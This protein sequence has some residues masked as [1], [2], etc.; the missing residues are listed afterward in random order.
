MSRAPSLLDDARRAYS[1]KAWD[2]AFRALSQID[3]A[4]GLGAEDLERLVWSASMLDLDAEIL[5]TMERL[6]QLHTD[7]D[8]KDRAGYWAFF[9]AFRLLATGQFG[10]ATAWLHRAERH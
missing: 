1:A 9:K 3:A 4:E 2:D 8:D 5:A 10:Q 6:Y 7:A